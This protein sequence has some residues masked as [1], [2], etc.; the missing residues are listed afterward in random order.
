M[1][2]ATLPKSAWHNTALTILI[3][4][5]I[6]SFLFNYRNMSKVLYWTL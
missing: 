6:M 1:G 4:L 5:H 3:F 2:W